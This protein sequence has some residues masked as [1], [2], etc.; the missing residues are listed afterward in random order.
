MNA[1]IPDEISERLSKRTLIIALAGI[2]LV[3]NFAWTIS[4]HMQ[5]STLH[6]NVTQVEENQAEMYEFVGA[7]AANDT[8][9]NGSADARGGTFSA[10]QRS[11][12]PLVGFDSETE[13]GRIVSLQISN[14]PGNRVYMDVTG[15]T[16]Q[17]SIQ[18]TMLVSRYHAIKMVGA[19]LNDGFVV[20]VDAPESW[21]YVGGT[22]SGLATTAGMIA[23]HERWKYDRR[24][25]LTGAVREDGSVGPVKH[26]RE[27]AIAAREHGY[28]TLV[29]PAGQG[30][31]VEG[32]E[33]VEVADV[34]TAMRYAIVS[35]RTNL[36]E[37]K[38]GGLTPVGNESSTTATPF[39]TGTPS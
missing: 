34:E 3:A 29:V 19:G 33:V 22:S 15:I 18:S 13:R 7:A 10:P 8:Q 2:L 36:N 30:V 26:I 12:V 21:E 1:P 31:E 37:S 20:K 38:T 25:V 4:L 28:E 14:V 27:K 6:E 5:V 9:Y 16:Y 17:P 23:S 32:I 39:P 35:E 11:A 24:V